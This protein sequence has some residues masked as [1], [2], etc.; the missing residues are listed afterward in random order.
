VLD[1]NLFTTQPDL[2]RDSLRRRGAK[3]EAL[4]RVDRLVALVAERR[5]LG[6]EGD[7]CRATRNE[8]SPKIGLAMKEGRKDDAERMKAEV[9][10]ASERAA[11]I[12]AEL[13]TVANEESELL[14]DLPN[15]V[16]ERTPDGKDEHSNVV[17]R[18]WGETRK[19]GRPHE[20]IAQALGMYDPDRAAKLS[21]S[22]FY[23]LSGPLAAMERALIQLFLDLAV[24][25]H[26]YREV[27]VPYMV[28]RTSM[29]GTGQLP[30]FEEDLFK[31]NAQLANEDAY[32]IPT[33]E[34]PVT[35]LHR[36]EILDEAALPLRYA[37]FTPCFRS[38]AGSWGRDTK[39]LIRLHQFH[40]VELV[41]FCRPEDAEAALD[42]L[43][44]HAQYALEKLGL[45]YQ[46]VARCAGDV[47][48]GGT[49]GFDLE[50]WLPGQQAYREISS[51]TWFGD[52]QSRRLKIRFKREGDKKNTL[53]HT[54][55][56][57]GLAV[58]RTLVAILE[59]YLQEDGS[60]IVPEVL[61]P[62]MRGLDR[63]QPGL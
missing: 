19:S 53:V 3:P 35:N 37:A 14:L 48:N 33:A 13:Q 18:T 49:K 54:L 59:N 31:L 46:T 2:V 38:E 1:P 43:T 41:W 6:A 28:T 34:V 16:H 62:Y 10:A 9:K 30:K 60:V 55:N 22:R 63:I 20:E 24:A 32:L 23:V 21:G 56:G 57:S 52:F 25:E 36:D 40:K 51:C 8:L 12:D 50:V 47:G 4:A 7:V 29:T 5:R 45:P 58:G 11:V 26:G 39:G 17:V 42:A 44:G 15:L 27:M 61:R